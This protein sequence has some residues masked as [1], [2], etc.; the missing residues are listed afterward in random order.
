MYSSCFR[1]SPPGLVRWNAFVNS[2]ISTIPAMYSVC[3]RDASFQRYTI[4]LLL[5]AIVRNTTPTDWTLY[6]HWLTWVPALQPLRCISAVIMATTQR[7]QQTFIYKKYSEQ[8]M[9][10]IASHYINAPSF[11]IFANSSF[12]SI[13]CWMWIIISVIKL[14]PHFHD[15]RQRHIYYHRC[16][17]SQ[18][19]GKRCTISS[20]PYY[21]C[22][23]E[24]DKR[25]G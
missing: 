23:C 3:S 25:V 14:K 12:S 1:P 2:R 9:C 15:T 18:L 7:S 11:K 20:I 13:N 22:L 16:S 21:A 17:Y 19:R 8:V 6:T 4:Q 5:F 10:S 24:Q